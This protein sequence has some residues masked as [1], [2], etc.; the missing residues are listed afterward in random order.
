[1][2]GDKILIAPYRKF[3][4]VL[5]LKNWGHLLLLFFTLCLPYWMAACTSSQVS[6]HL[7]AFNGFNQ[8]LE[9]HPILLYVLTARWLM[10]I[11]ILLFQKNQILS[12]ISSCSMCDRLLFTTPP[13]WYD[14]L[15]RVLWKQ[16]C[17]LQVLYKFF[18]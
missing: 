9:Y 7:T 12:L 16:P 2:T 6:C 13:D 10:S 11:I 8:Y 3:K 5:Q 14:P 17:Y 18:L 1:M 15:F 4:T